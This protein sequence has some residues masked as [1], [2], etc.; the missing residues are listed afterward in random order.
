MPNAKKPDLSKAEITSLCDAAQAAW[1]AAQ[2]SAKRVTFTWNGK[3]Y[4]SRLTAFRMLVETA[5][6]EPVAARYH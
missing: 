4:Q 1:D 6:G 5:T 3:K 2:P